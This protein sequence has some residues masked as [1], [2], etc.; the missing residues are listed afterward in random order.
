MK[1]NYFMQNA[2]TTKTFLHMDVRNNGRKWPKLLKGRYPLMKATMAKKIHKNSSSSTCSSSDNNIG[3][4]D[5]RF[6]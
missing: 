5:E 4:Y 6:G 2:S 1:R 3:R